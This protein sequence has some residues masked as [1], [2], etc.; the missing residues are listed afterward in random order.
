MSDFSKPSPIDHDPLL[1]SSLVGQ[2]T[3]RGTP[4][5]ITNRIPEDAPP[6]KPHNPH[7][8][9]PRPT[10]MCLIPAQELVHRGSWPTQLL[11][12]PKPPKPRCHTF[13]LPRPA[14]ALVVNSTMRME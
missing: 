13:L 4:P 12:R 11:S 3:E 2:P 1:F 10:P 14:P 5:F 6:P 9:V 8:P 7:A